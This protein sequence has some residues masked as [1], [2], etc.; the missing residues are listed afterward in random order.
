MTKAFLKITIICAASSMMM[1]ASAWAQTDLVNQPVGNLSNS[2]NNQSWS[3]KRLSAT[4][5][6]EEQ[7]VRASKLIGTQVSDSS[8]QRVGQIQD[9]IVNTSS[10]RIDFALL[11]LNANTSFPSS[12]N[13]VPGYKPG[14]PNAGSGDKLVPV[15][16]ALLRA[17]SSSQYSDADSQQ[18][19]F[20]LNADQNKLNNAPKVD[21]SDLSQSQ[22][23]QR[24]YAYYGVTPESATGAAESPQGQIIHSGGSREQSTSIRHMPPTPP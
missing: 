16:W 14:S 22:W 21:W 10:G 2:Q 11:S 4:G 19:A 18:P 23:R 3:T 20:T 12:S 24:I 6:N 15:P 5:R 17:S 1:A 9:V 7:A 8:G 13:S